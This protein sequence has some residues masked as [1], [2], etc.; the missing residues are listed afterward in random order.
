[1]TGYILCL[2]IAKALSSSLAPKEMSVFLFCV[3]RMTRGIL[4]SRPGIE[5]GPQ[6]RKPGILTPGHQGTPRNVSLWY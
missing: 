2:L 6:Q 3:C 5:L 4:A 1:M